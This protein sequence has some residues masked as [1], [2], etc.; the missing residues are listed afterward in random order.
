MIDLTLQQ[1]KIMPRYAV[2]FSAGSTQELSERAWVILFACIS[3]HLNN[4]VLQEE[5][6]KS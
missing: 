3:T 4:S 2:C 1:P 5:K 6:R